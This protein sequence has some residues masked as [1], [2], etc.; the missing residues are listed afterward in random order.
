MPEYLPDGISFNDG[1]WV[2]EAGG[3]AAFTD[4]SKSHFS[5]NDSTYIKT[6]TN[7]ALL[8]VSFT[9]GWEKSKPMSMWFRHRNT[10][11]EQIK[12]TLRQN[13]V[14]LINS[15]FL[16]PSASF[17][18]GSL[19]IPANTIPTNELYVDVVFESSISAEGEIDVS[20]LSLI[21][22]DL[23]IG[24]RLSMGVGT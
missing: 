12:Y 9:S 8:V 21:Q 18:D 22:G 23:P 17:A 15:G 14:N 5:P 10:S 2:D 19:F 1:N 11:T 4:V 20:Q 7:G 6:L 24:S 16:T 13:G 3:A